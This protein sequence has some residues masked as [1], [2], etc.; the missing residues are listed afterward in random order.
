MVPEGID[1]RSRC[2]ELRRRRF[3][4]RHREVGRDPVR[5]LET[6]VGERVCEAGAAVLCQ[7][8]RVDASDLGD[9]SVRVVAELLTDV[10]A[11][12][13]SHAVVVTKN[14]DARSKSTREFAVNIDHRN[15]RLHCLDCNLGECRAIGGQQNDGVDSV[16]DEPFDLSDLQVGVVRSLGNL[17]VDVGVFGGFGKRC[18]VDCAEPTVICRGAREPDGDGVALR[19]IAL[20]AGI[21]GLS[22]VCGFSSRTAG[23]ETDD[24]E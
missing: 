9:N 3:S 7:R 6:T 23:D 5:N 11:C 20:D 4:T 18:S 14:R 17:Q 1:L 13:H 12:A 16:V 15:A 22:V 10:R 8:Q 2:E 21:R 24:G 19:L